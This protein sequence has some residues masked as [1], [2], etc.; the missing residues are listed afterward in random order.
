MAS[1]TDQNGQ[2]T[3][4]NEQLKKEPHR[5]DFF[6]AMRLL[7]L[8]SLAADDPQRR[9]VGEDYNPEQEIVRFRALPSLRFPPSPISSI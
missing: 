5:F 4:L 1:Q 9:P 7:R 8:F 6:Q 3:A 2:L